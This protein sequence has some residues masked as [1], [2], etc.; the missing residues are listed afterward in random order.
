VDFTKLTL[1]EVQAE[2][3]EVVGDVRATFEP[4]D[5]HQLN[6]R[7]TPAAWS[8]AQCIDHL[9]QANHQMYLAMSRACEPGASRTVWQRLPALPRIFGRVLITSQAPTGERKFT[10][11]RKATPAASEIDARVVDRFADG[12]QEMAGFI[13][14]LAGRDPARIIMVSP[15]V[16]FITY[17]VLDGLRLIAA[18]ERRHYEQARRVISLLPLPAGGG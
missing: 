12:Q 1:A 16:R 8:A 9:V 3:V 13:R 11:P 15:F 18:H 5:L 4:L 17:S 7:P 14:A 2:L 6:W 10:A